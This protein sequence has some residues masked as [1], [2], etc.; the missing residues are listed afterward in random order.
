MEPKAQLQNVL[1]FVKKYWHFALVC[2]ILTAGM[3]LRLEAYLLNKSFW[4]DEAQL[5]CNFIENTGFGAFL[6]PLDY[7]QI[8]PPVFLLAVKILTMLT[9]NSSLAMS[10]P[11]F[12]FIPFI[13]S[14]ISVPAFYILSKKFLTQRRAV[15]F[16][17]TLFAINCTLIR[18]ACEFKQYSSDVLIF[19]LLFIL[20]SNNKTD[21]FFA[22]LNFAKIFISSL[23]FTLLFFLSQTSIFA[24]SGLVGYYFI[25]SRFKNLKILS[26]LIIP[27][28]SI[29]LYKASIPKDFSGFMEMYWENGFIS[30]SNILNVIRLNTEYFIL[31]QKY[32]IFTL[33]L[34]IAGFVKTFF[35]KTK[36]NRIFL[37]TLFGILSA[38]VLR[39]Y[40]FL[41]RTI[42]YFLPFFIILISKCLDFEINAPQNAPI[43]GIFRNLHLKNLPPENIS[44][45]PVRKTVSFLYY[46]SIFLVV[47]LFQLQIICKTRIDAFFNISAAREA[48]VILNE[49]FNPNADILIVP[50]ASYTLY[51]YYSTLFHTNNTKRRIIFIKSY[52]DE[53]VNNELQRLFGLRGLR[54]FQ[55]F[56]NLQELQDKKV[57]SS[58]LSHI[59]HSGLFDSANPYGVQSYW[60]YTVHS[61]NVKEFLS[62]NNV[63]TPYEIRLS[64]SHL[65]K[66]YTEAA[67]N[68]ARQSLNSF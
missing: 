58:N 53:R 52:K 8:A 19:M 47:I 66:I 35:E 14:I 25:K 23:S 1:S 37:L 13:S 68:T 56:P 36:I 4:H 46:L 10:E 26:I 3:S 7:F 34:L 62:A 67:P 38:S 27:L 29:L 44:S 43:T 22:N 11:V 20:F 24:L 2:F 30:F 15:I 50:G 64:N 33:P 51:K 28:V 45:T 57:Q 49:N 39:L 5:A 42:L 63:F 32:L 59:S 41:E 40:P 54:G 60:I 61:P 18:Y 48:F 55:K 12:R 31:G 9:A 65:Y 16:A 17:S 6:K 21:K